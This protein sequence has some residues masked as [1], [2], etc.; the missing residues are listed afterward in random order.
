M[1]VQE[2]ENLLS[3]GLMLGTVGQVHG[4]VLALGLRVGI[5]LDYGTTATIELR[6]IY[7]MQMR[8]LMIAV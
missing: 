8:Y 6:L 4:R 1:G 7:L 5:R 3:E 2:V